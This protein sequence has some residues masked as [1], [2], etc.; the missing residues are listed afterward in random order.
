MAGRLSQARGVLLLVGSVVLPLWAGAV[1][2]VV[3]PP[4]QA[5]RKTVDRV[6]A[7][8]EDD[9]M[10]QPARLSERRQLLEEVIGARFSYEEMSKRALA[11]QWTRLSQAERDEFVVLFRSFLSD[12]YADKIEGYAGEDV[13]YLSERVEGPY[14]EVRTRVASGK[15]EIPMDYRLLQLSGEWRVYDVVVDGVSLVRN[16]RG[17]F[18]KIIRDSSYAE[19]VRRLRER[20]QKRDS[21]EELGR[22]A[23]S[24]ERL[25]RSA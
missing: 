23:P 22:A 6:L 3:D 5:V 14:A 24:Q 25:E 12:R 4:T 9:A 18:H 16:Y 17:Q 2:A 11:A 20:T 7:I 19:L 21:G 13:R 15:V 1:G 8:L 10:K